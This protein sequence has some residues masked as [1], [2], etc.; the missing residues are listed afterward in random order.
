MFEKA[1]SEGRKAK[2]LSPSQNWSIA[3][4]G[5]ALA[6]SGKQSEARAVLDELLGLSKTRYVPPYHFALIYNALGEGEKAL[7][8]LEK[9]FAEKDVRMVFLKVEPKW[10]NLRSEPRFVDLMRRMNF[11]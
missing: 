10:N 8:Y 1:F 6:K 2:R 7:D 5:Y 11:E 4:G 9:G 3:F